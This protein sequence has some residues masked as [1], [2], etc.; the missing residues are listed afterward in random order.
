MAWLATARR[1]E[2][3]Q[4]VG[5]TPSGRDERKQAASRA[6]RRAYRAAKSFQGDLPHALRELAIMAAIDCYLFY[7]LR[8][9]K[10]L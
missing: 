2:L 8:K 9:A 6:A 7:R 4:H 5:R 1:L 3:D 10:W